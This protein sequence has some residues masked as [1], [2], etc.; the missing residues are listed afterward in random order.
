MRDESQRICSRGI[1]KETGN[2]QHLSLNIFW[3]VVFI[4]LN[5]LKLG[6]IPDFDGHIFLVGG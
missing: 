2:L 3:V 6:K 1:P 5:P 4:F